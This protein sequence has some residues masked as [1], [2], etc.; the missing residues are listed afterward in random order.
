MTIRNPVVWPQ[1]KSTF[2]IFIYKQTNYFEHRGSPFTFINQHNNSNVFQI[3]QLEFI[4]ILQFACMQS[5]QT[6]YLKCSPATNLKPPCH[7]LSISAH[8]K[9]ANKTLYTNFK[10]SSTLINI[11]NLPTL[12][13]DFLPISGVYT[14]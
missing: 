6:G 14:Y 11:L 12:H 4:N 2:G 5:E 3:T 8:R 9:F 10:H 7:I 13:I 1:C